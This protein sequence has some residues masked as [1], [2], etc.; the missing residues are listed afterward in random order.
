VHVG[1]DYSRV[2]N[3]TNYLTSINYVIAGNPVP[4]SRDAVVAQGSYNGVGPRI[5]TDLSYLWHEQFSVYGK[6]AVAVLAGSAK[7]SFLGANVVTIGY[8]RAMVVPEIDAKLG[9][10]YSH[11]ISSGSI[12]ADAGWLWVNYFNPI[13]SANIAPSVVSNQNNNFGIQGLYFGLKW[14][15]DLGHIVPHV[16]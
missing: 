10:T 9:V 3:T 11:P 15:G 14:A 6:A 2:S 5:G 1:F 4:T 7:S 8:D 12:T 13:V 16:S